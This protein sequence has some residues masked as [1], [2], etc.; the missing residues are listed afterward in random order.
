MTTKVSEGGKGLKGGGGVEI[1]K[2][3][4]YSVFQAAPYLAVSGP[5]L[6]VY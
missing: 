1:L 5:R 3:P 4:P 6:R 2:R